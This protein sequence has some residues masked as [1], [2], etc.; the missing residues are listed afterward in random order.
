MKNALALLI[1]ITTVFGLSCNTTKREL[2]E[3]NRKARSLHDEE[4]RRKEICLAQQ[5]PKPHPS[6][7]GIDPNCHRD[8]RSLAWVLIQEQKDQCWVEKS[9]EINRESFST[10]ST[11]E[12]V[13]ALSRYHRFQ[14]NSPL[15][16]VY[17]EIAIIEAYKGIALSPEDFLPWYILS[18][19]LTE[20]GVPFEK[21]GRALGVQ[22]I[23]HRKVKV[24][25]DDVLG[26][27]QHWISRGQAVIAI[28]RAD[29]LANAVYARNV[30]HQNFLDDLARRT[31]GYLHAVWITGIDQSSGSP[32]I[33]FNDTA[34]HHAPSTVDWSTL[35]SAIDAA[36]NTFIITTEKIPALKQL[37]ISDGVRAKEQAIQ[38]V[39][40][41]RKNRLENYHRAKSA[42][43]DRLDRCI[44]EQP[45]SDPY[46]F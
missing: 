26:H 21:I 22:Q 35:K 1:L 8:S 46:G 40:R 4:F 42:W 33:Y 2:Q 34:V 39:E 30:V 43:E 20:A 7:F 10:P 44:K 5:N 29:I 37:E 17:S 36:G 24:H 15:C 9:R 12:R 19:T 23:P 25:A 3:H 16:A 27:I 18:G 13:Q 45:D 14:G 6:T 11:A 41:Q 28:L 31:N 32:R 38:R